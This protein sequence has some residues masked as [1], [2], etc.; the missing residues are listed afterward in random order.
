MLYLHFI[1]LSQA[2]GKSAMM[3]GFQMFLYNKR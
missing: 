3:D 2:D 1:L